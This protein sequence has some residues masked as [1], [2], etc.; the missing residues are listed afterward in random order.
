MDYQNAS[1]ETLH[2]L[3]KLRFPKIGIRATDDTNRNA[4]VALLKNTETGTSDETLYLLLKSRLPGIDIRK[5]DDSNRNTFIALLKII[6]PTDGQEKNQ[7]V[8]G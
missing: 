8:N 2:S 5:I 7:D 3:L 6:E 4:V 1:D